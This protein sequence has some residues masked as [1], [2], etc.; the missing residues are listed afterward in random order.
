MLKALGTLLLLTAVVSACA[1]AEDAPPDPA[2]AARVAAGDDIVDLTGA[3]ATFPY[4]VYARWISRFAGET[5]LRINYRS[6]GTGQGLA[7][8]TAGTVDFGASDAPLDAVEADPSLVQLPLVVGGVVVT[9]NVPEVT[10]PLRLDGALLAEIF[11]GRVARWD[12]RRIRALNPGVALPNLSIKLITRLDPSGTTLVFTRFLAA[13]SAAWDSS[14]GVGLSVPFPAGMTRAGNEGVASEVKVTY[15]AIGYVEQS[16]AMLNRLPT[17]Q[18]Q[19]ASG[20]Y[21]AASASSLI[22]A[23][24][25]AG[26]AP[27]ADG[28]PAS[29][30]GASAPEA[31]PIA[32][33]SWIVVPQRSSSSAAR[34]TLLDFIRWALAD[35][36]AE[37]A[38][39]GYAPVPTAVR[40]RVE[41]IVDSL[42]RSEGSS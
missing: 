2:D 11:A 27:R 21:V 37:A 16:Y 39:L 41:A 5:G 8:V 6:V 10:A 9:Y 17:A 33:F 19:N 3:G 34:T 30:L 35:G 28:L 26:G 1:P 12:D 13:S 20:S 24:N 14:P 7:Q 18:V 38:Q 4:P 23:A 36:G 40:Q 25:S 22:A 42:R 15:G 31:Y 32:E 29:L